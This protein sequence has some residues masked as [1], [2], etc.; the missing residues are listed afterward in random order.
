MKVTGL[1]DS[2]VSCVVTVE[3]GDSVLSLKNRVIDA[4]EMSNP[5]QGAMG[6]CV[7]GCSTPLEETVRVSETEL[8]VSNDSHGLPAVPGHSTFNSVRQSP[9]EFSC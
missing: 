5:S 6:L 8:C 4:L 9:G 7:A 2:G 1:S 3:S